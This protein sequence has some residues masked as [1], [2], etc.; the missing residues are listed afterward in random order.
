MSIGSPKSRPSAALGSHP[1]VSSQSAPALHSAP[2]EATRRLEPPPQEPSSPGGLTRRV[3][4]SH[5]VATLA[6][7]Q[8]PLQDSKQESRQESKQ[9][10]RQA[11]AV[12]PVAGGLTRSLGFH[13]QQPAVPLEGEN[14]ATTVLLESIQHAV[15][16]APDSSVPSSGEATPQTRPVTPASQDE[17]DASPRLQAIRPAGRGNTN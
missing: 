14:D 11:P 16:Q 17:A 5:P 4:Q 6:G 2:P 9:D 13:R 15:Q 7:P 12:V 8:A 10:S 1:L 3:R